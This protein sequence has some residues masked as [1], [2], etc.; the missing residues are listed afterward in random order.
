MARGPA[1]LDL[2]ALTMRLACVKL[3]HFRRS[4]RPQR[5]REGVVSRS[6]NGVP[7]NLADHVA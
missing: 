6:L 1:A 7:G 3:R 2:G 5:G 4:K